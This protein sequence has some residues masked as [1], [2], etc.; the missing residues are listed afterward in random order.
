MLVAFLILLAIVFLGVLADTIGLSVTTADEKPFH[1]MAARKVPGAME[2]IRLLRNAER[3]SSI[4]NDV[5]GDICGVVSGSASA[6][7]AAQVLQNFDFSWS[8]VVPLLLSA[9]VAG[10]TVAGK[11]IGKS[12]ALNSCTQIVSA[13]GSL[14]YYLGHIGDLFR[15]K[16]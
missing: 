9:L 12:F 4:C 13:V 14:I 6:T 15:K 16:K 1:S 8:Q 7:I 11:A 3:V 10:L 2:S 5:I